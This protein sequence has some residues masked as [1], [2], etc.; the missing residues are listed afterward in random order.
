[1][2]NDSSTLKT[3]QTWLHHQRSTLFIF[4]YLR[5]EIFGINNLTVCGYRLSIIPESSMHTAFGVLPQRKF[6]KTCYLQSGRI[7]KIWP[8]RKDSHF[9]ANWKALRNPSAASGKFYGS[10]RALI[11]RFE[12]TYHKTWDN[13][14]RQWY[15]GIRKTIYRLNCI[16]FKSITMHISSIFLSL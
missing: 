1:L 12:T 5:C 14:A 7:N 11:S 15:L 2:A 4:G 8:D 6:W 13:W 10:S 9:Q 3:R 16:I